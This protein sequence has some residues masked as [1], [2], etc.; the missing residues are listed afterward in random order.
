[1]VV[2]LGAVGWF[3]VLNCVGVVGVFVWGWL[4]YGWVLGF[5]FC[6][7]DCVVVCVCLGL[8][9]KLC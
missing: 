8:G 4:L 3:W 2:G 1:M 7:I 6:L 5:L 9:F